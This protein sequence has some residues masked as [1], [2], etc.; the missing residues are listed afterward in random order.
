MYSHLLA[1]VSV[2]A[3]V[4]SAML[5]V[6]NF[7]QNTYKRAPLLLAWLAIT[8][9]ATYIGY[10]LHLHDGFNFSLIS[11]ACL[12]SMIVGLLL[13]L[14]TL[15]KPVEKL[16]VIVFPVAAAMLALELCLPEKSRSL[17][18]NDW[19]ITAHVLSSIIAFSLINIAALQAIMLAIQNQ[20]LKSHPPKRFIQ[21]LPPL[22]TMEILLFQM[23]SVGLFFLTVSLAS[24]FIF[25]KDL[26]AQHLVHKTV[27]S[28]LAWII[29]TSLLVGRYRYGWRGKIAIQWTLVGFVLLLLAYFGSKLVLEIILNRV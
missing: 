14:A 13:M 7:Y 17:H 2:L 3:Y 21:S 20:Q 12:I 25:I 9:H 29:F 26:F 19:E 1:L 27:L 16:G 11:T 15:N 24:G 8:T 22:Q 10:S 28:I 18:S 23:L 6:R 5:I 4:S